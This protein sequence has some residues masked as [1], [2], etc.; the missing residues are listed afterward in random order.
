[1]L[2]LNYLLCSLRPHLGVIRLNKYAGV[3]VGV[4]NGEAV[5]EVGA[6]AP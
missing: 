4:G 3:I 5:A 2:W 6:G 1:M